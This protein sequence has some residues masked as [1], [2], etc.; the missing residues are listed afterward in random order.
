MCARK[1][2]IPVFVT[3]GIGGVHREGEKSK[4]LPSS[5]GFLPCPTF[6][7]LAL[8]ISADLIE[9]GRTAVAVVCAGI[10]SILDIGRTLEYL[11]TQG[12]PVVTIGQELSFP[13]FFTANSG[14]KAPHHVTS[15]SQAARI[16]G[17]VYQRVTTR[18]LLH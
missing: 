18:E 12:V 4:S 8:D 14:Y 13:S 9:L 15:P 7:P 1:A 2:G 5:F 11:E 16:I 10:K 17:V 3:G 6:L